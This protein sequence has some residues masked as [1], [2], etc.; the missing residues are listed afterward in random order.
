MLDPLGIAIDCTLA[1]TWHLSWMFMLSSPFLII[2]VLWSIQFILLSN[3]ILF[4]FLIIYLLA[5][6]SLESLQSKYL[7]SRA[8][9]GVEWG[10]RL[11]K[12]R[13]R[14]LNI[15]SFLSVLYY[16]YVHKNNEREVKRETLCCGE[17]IY[18]GIHEPTTPSAYSVTSGASRRRDASMYYNWPWFIKQ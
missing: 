8:Q 11:V 14:H 17:Y 12:A 6:V 16:I 2:S 9:C 3:F 13:A 10:N 7:R 4:Y 18:S 15:S 5:T 1:A